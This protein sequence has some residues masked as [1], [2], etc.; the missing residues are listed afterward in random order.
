MPERGLVEKETGH[1]C[2]KMIVD[3]AIIELDRKAKQTCL[4]HSAGDRIQMHYH[5]PG[6]IL[7]PF[8]G[9][10]L[11]MEVEWQFSDLEKVPHAKDSGL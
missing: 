3:G 4:Y 6:W 1:R 8:K 2:C 5:N 9:M 10:Q 11:G 7:V